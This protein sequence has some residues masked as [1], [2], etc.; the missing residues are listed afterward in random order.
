[1]TEVFNWFI[2]GWIGVALVTFL[3]LLKVTAP[4]GRHSSTTWGPMI[5]NKLSWMIMEAP[6]GLLVLFLVLFG[7]VEIELPAAIFT[8]LFVLHYF[9]RSVIYPLRTKT[10]GK[11]V[12]LVI[13]FSAIFFNL[14][15]GGMIGY[16]LGFVHHYS[17]DWLTSPQMI[18]GLLAFITGAYINIQ[19]DNILLNLRRP[20]ETGYKIPQGGLFNYVSCPNLFGEMV[21]WIGFAIMTWSLPGAAFAIWTIANLL[22]RALDHHKFYLERFEHYPLD[23]KAVIPGVL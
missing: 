12:P 5:S 8:G 2:Y 20:R 23:R 15:N 4:Y 7:S 13:T 1:M 9:N 6:S 11:K 17:Y 14:V 10:E 16:Y 18:V 22:P 21:E 19:S 3:I